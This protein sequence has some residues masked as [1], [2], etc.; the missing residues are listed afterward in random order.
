MPAKS[1]EQSSK[2]CSAQGSECY[3]IP[4]P[5]GNK[6]CKLWETYCNELQATCASANASGPPPFKSDGET[7]LKKLDSSKVVMGNG[8]MDGAPTGTIQGASSAQAS[9]P[10]QMKVAPTPY[11]QYSSPVA[12]P[13]ST[14]LVVAGAGGS[15][16][17][18]DTC[19]AN[20]GQ[21]CVPGMCCSS[22]G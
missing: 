11:Q 9:V 19:G 15:A 10:A 16:G 17:S 3:S 18:T 6:G 2:N 4:T 13:Q 14:A 8:P 22:H 21:S 5:I 7:S 12:V 1:F 20:G